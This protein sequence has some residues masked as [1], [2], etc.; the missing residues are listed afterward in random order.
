MILFN[1]NRLQNIQIILLML[2]FLCSISCSINRSEQSNKSNYVLIDKDDSI[3]EIIKKAASVT[4]SERQFAWQ[5]L[6]F[7]GFVHFTINTFTDKEWGDG[8]E[9]P[10]LFNPV[11]FDADQWVKVCKEAGMKLLLV[12]A[13]H[14]DGF[15]LWPSKYTEHSVKNS[16]WLNGKGD[17]VREVSEACKRHNIKFGVYLSPW[18]RHEPVYGDSPEY[19]KYFKN[20]LTELL[21]NYGD[22]AEVW[23]DGACGEGPNGKRQIYD[24][25]GYYGLIRKLQPDAVIAIMGP[26]VRWVGTETGYGRDTEWSVIPVKLTDQQKIAA[27]SQ[28][29]INFIPGSDRTAENLG[30]REK[31]KNAK[32]LVWYP[33]EVDVSIRPGWFYH[34]SQDSRVKTPEKLLD[35]YYSSIGKNSLLLMNLPPDRRGLIHENDIASLKQMRRILDVTFDKNFAESA[36]ISASN[37][38]SGHNIEYITDADKNTYWTT[39]DGV[40]SAVIEFTFQKNIR[41]DR[42]LLQEN[43]RI[44]QRVEEFVLETFNNGNW[45]KVTE[46][47]TIGYKRLLRFSA[48]ET[49][50]VR[51]RILESRTSPSLNKIGF[52]KAPPSVAINPAQGAFVD[53]IEVSLISDD[54]NSTIYYTLNGERPSINSKTYSKPVILKNTAVLQ[55]FAKSSDGKTGL[56]ISAR[57]NKSKHGIVLK[58]SFSPKYSGGGNLALIDGEQGSTGFDDGK[59]QGY[60][61]NDL[62]A[63]IDLGGKKKVKHVSVDFLQNVNSWIFLPKSVTVSFSRDGRIF[64]N[65]KR[66]YHQISLKKNEAFKHNFSI[67]GKFETR[68]IR[69]LAENIKTCPEW[70][71]GAG[72]K[73][74]IFADE[75]VIE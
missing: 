43:I 37:S 54:P 53:K 23:F 12:T 58:S 63:V 66:I 75:I 74:W 5:E 38:K 49:E 8:T 62:D 31:L 64:S 27:L 47:T 7:T 1:K 41:F 40:E 29:D 11:E 4:P 56:I 14:H 36:K 59:W 35:I 68:F 17:I 26:D 51:L 60:E 2:V 52:Y 39:E 65:L 32:K 19:N 10:A 71:K 20:Q 61:G 24:W 15:C 42:L 25:E 34:S 21:T 28:H 70:H 55:A 67:T 30:S 72:G 48:L 46:G 6:E 50:K 3:E 22:V 57:F 9:D 18:D 45:E 16:P 44:G 69:I 33:S 73:T 13:K